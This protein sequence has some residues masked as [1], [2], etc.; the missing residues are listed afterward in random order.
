[1]AGSRGER[2]GVADLN[3]ALSGTVYG[4]SPG[5]TAAWFAE[6]VE[7]NGVDL[8][9]SPRW[10][11]AGVF[12]GAA[13]LA[14]RGKRAWV[15]AFGVV[16]AFRGHG[17]ARRY[18]A[19]LQAIAADADATG[20]ELEVLE[21]NADA[22]RLYERGGFEQTGELIVWAR[23]PLHAPGAALREVT[24]EREQRD[25]AAVRAIARRPPTCW[26]REPPSVAAAPAFETIVVGPRAAPSAYAFLRRR[27]PSGDVVLD[28]GASDAAGAAALLDALDVHAAGQ[29][30]TVLN[31]PPQ[32]ALHEAF[33]A[34]PGWRELARQRRMRARLR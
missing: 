29:T 12:S 31:E 24:L 7:R 22:I 3:A 15:G 26:Q 20:I 25:L 2:V 23:G 10:S 34:N 14:L 11:V 9:R 30:L 5:M 18:L 17:L 33:A 16:P 27:G 32:G 21:H 19:E 28:A 4:A 6:H 13:L 8:Q 1:M